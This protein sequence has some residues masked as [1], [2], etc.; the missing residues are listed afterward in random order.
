MDESIFRKK[1]IERIQSPDDL[2]QYIKVAEPGV[3]LLII[4]VVSILTGFLVWG[5]FGTVET[6]VHTS[7]VVNAGQA[8]CQ[9]VL[10]NETDYYVGMPVYIADKVYY[11]SE[12]IPD[13]RNTRVTLL[14]NT[15]I[16]NGVY[17]AEIVTEALSP[18]SFILN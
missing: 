6:R 14:I 2:T 9:T 3:W 5:V 18:L 8:T 7:A 16:K 1:S 17:Q 10:D 15:D 12:I 4:A 13:Y 11:A